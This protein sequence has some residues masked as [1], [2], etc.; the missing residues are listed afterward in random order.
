M[1]DCPQLVLFRQ[2]IQIGGIE[3]TYFTASL[4]SRWRNIQ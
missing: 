1:M 2:R 4:S 3:R